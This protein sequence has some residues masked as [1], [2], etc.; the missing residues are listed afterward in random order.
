MNCTAISPEQWMEFIDGAVGDNKRLKMDDHLTSCAACREVHERLLLS[1]EALGR[2]LPAEADSSTNTRL[3]NNVRFR[4]R[5]FV[6][7]GQPDAAAVDVRQLRSILVSMCGETGADGALHK[8]TSRAGG[9]MDRHFAAN[10][11]SI[12]EVMCGTQAARLVE[13]AAKNVPKDR[14]A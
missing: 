8:A 2:A 1:R 4:I 7:S 6:G 10:L 14:V 5:R 3:W 9:T 13:D 12:I 11:G